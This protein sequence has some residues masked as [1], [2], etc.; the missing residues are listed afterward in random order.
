MQEQWTDRPECRVC[1]Q[2]D[3]M[4]V[5]L[6]VLDLYVQR[7]QQQQSPA[8]MC[9]TSML[10]Q[11]TSSYRHVHTFAL[12]LH[13]AY[14]TQVLSFREHKSSRLH[15]IRQPT[16]RLCCG[17]TFDDGLLPHRETLLGGCP[18][19]VAADDCIDSLDFCACI[20]WLDHSTGADHRSRAFQITPSAAL[21]LSLSVAHFS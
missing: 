5:F 16:R 8:L 12:F 19:L 4:V 13:S 14:M 11:P 18:P 6:R 20:P 2:S 9:S 17:A 21:S 15:C 7:V 10:L 1:A 3:M